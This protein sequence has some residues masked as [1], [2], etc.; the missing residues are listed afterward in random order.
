MAITDVGKVRKINEDAV[1]D[2]PADGM[3][4]V[5]DGM[6]GHEAGD[7]A[8]QLI[9]ERLSEVQSSP[10]LNRYVE[11]V[12]DELW[13]I[14]QLLQKEADVRGKGAIG[15]TVV[16]L[17]A[18]GN[19]YACL[20]AGDSRAYLLT[21][22]MFQAVSRD[23]SQVE[24]FVQQGLLTRDEAEKHPAANLITR[25]VGAVDNLVVD[26]EFGE[27][28]PGDLFLLCSDGLYKE[29]SEAE[30]EQWMRA[31]YAYD[32]LTKRLVALTLERGA[33]DNTS[34]ISIKV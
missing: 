1:L 18:V 13:E 22:D 27:L 11:D 14:N 20:W 12:Q 26:V 16:V 6:G 30:I 8:S 17:L 23:H 2:R 3:W 25:A 19:Q 24:E 28:V 7:F 21:N 34:V 33:R 9:I 4:V 29:V 31:E 5:A 10:D 32:E 15:S